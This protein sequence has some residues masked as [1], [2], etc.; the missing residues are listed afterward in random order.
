MVTYE[1]WNQA[2][3]KYFFDDSDP[4]EMVFLQTNLETLSEIAEHF[5]I[6]VEDVAE[7][8][9]A[10]VRDKVVCYGRVN[11]WEIYPTDL[12]EDN[13]EKEP[14]QVAFLALTVLAASLMESSDGAFHTNYYIR[15]NEVLFGKSI[16]GEPR[17]FDRCRFEEFWK[18]LQRWARHQ[19][20]VELHW[21][22]GKSTRKYVWYPISQCLI[23]KHNQRTILR[24]FQDANLKP[25][26]HLAEAQLLSALRSWTSFTALP[27]KIRRPLERDTPDTRLILSQVNSLLTNWDGEPPPEISSGVKRHRP[28]LIHVQ[29]QLDLFDKVEVRYW[30]RRRKKTQIDL[31][32]NPLGIETLQLHDEKWFE[33]I[34]VP[35]DYRS[36]WKLQNRLELKS[37]GSKPLTFLLK[38]AEIWVFRCDPERD[39]GWLSQG[40]LLLHEEH[41]VVF[42]NRLAGEVTS[43]LQQVCDPE[44]F[45]PKSIYVA[46]EETGW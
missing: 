34:I 16:K 18:H 19:H 20:D 43:F 14:P 5:D 37:E 46:G 25:G 31:F 10:S 36:F 4:D 22:K 39:D 2:I 27:A 44:I 9:K 38:P 8:L 29:L 24:F 21:T 6:N 41:L 3:I 1:Q 42:R 13:P 33:P 15:L 30:F 32:P 45:S 12:W 7:S 40:N 26:A 23:N 11:L 17:G 28:I 35:D